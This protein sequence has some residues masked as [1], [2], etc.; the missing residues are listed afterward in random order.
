MSSIVNQS[1]HE[2]VKGRALEEIER[3]LSQAS[4]ELQT[5]KAE[6]DELPRQIEEATAN[7]DARR[8]GELEARGRELRGQVEQARARLW[9]L[10]AERARALLPE[11]E[12][13]AEAAKAEFDVAYAEYLEAHARTNRLGVEV[14]NA[15]VRASSL[16]YTAEE[17]ERKAKAAACRTPARQA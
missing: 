15:R 9:S 2:A 3:D 17:N 14:D 1:E 11:A 10:Q 5:L 16:R 13:R 12:E 7:L 6:R 8:L 4:E